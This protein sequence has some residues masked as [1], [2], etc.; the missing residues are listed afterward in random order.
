M[1]KNICIKVEY[2]GSPFAGWQR[3]LGSRTIQAEI[4]KIIQ[5]VTGQETAIYGAGRTDSGVHARGQV[6]NFFTDYRAEAE[7]WVSIFNYF[8]PPEIRVCESREMPLEFHSQRHALSKIYEYRVLNRRYASALDPHALFFPR[9]LDWER[10]REALP[11]FVGEKDFRSFQG[12]KANVKT[13]VR[14]ILRFELDDSRRSEG[15][16][17]LEI[18]GTGFL[19]QMVRAIVGTLLKVG[20]RRLD[21]S[22]LPRIIEGKDRR[23][24][25][26]TAPA[27]G[28]CLVKVNYGWIS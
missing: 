9:S 25:G 3:Q 23:L 16:Y 18:E 26:A 21:I 4:E 6:C 15:L 1:Q 28:L 17:R 12:A 2:D 5:R 8:L 11:L 7:R 10:I 20:E 24:A 22:G 14:E 27:C 13:T 19:K